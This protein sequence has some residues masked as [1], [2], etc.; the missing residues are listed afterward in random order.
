VSSRLAEPAE[1][2]RAA[3][4]EGQRVRFVGGAT[5]STWGRPIAAD[6]EVSTAEL[7][8]I[9]EHNAGDLTAVLGAGVPLAQAQDAFG[10]AGQM[11]ALDPPD[12]GA[13]VGGVLATGDSGPLR[14]RHGGPRDLVLGVQVALSDGTVARAGG[15][16]IKNV[17]GYDLA[18]LFTGSF[19]TLGLIVEVAVRLQPRPERTATAVLERDDGAEL[20]AAAAELARRPLEHEC[21]DLRWE[22]GAGAVLARFAGATAAERARAAGGAVVED[23]EELWERQRAGQ[24]SAA[25]TVVR[26][27]GTLTALPAVLAA[28]RRRGASV[29]ARAAVGLAWIAL[30]ERPPA[31]AAAAVSELR[32]ELA[33]STCV[34]QDAPAAVREAVDPWG[35]VQDGHLA[36]MRRVKARF[37]PAGACNPGLFVG[38]I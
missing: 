26:V 13:T 11:L 10:E 6:V 21:L 34:V 28:A 23:D 12:Q 8:E 29:V 27:S 37:D 18:K 16:V 3:A 33:P 35:P 9:V 30:P 20:C 25:G 36:L 7:D 15:K 14:H 19:G 22:D 24:R 31:E 38:G 32:A 5:K 17:A 4:A 1:M 2:L